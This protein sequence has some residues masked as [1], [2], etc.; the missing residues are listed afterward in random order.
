MKKWLLFSL[1]FIVIVFSVCSQVSDS[2][3]KIVIDKQVELILNSGESYI[4][5][6]KEYD[7]ANV[8]FLKDDG[9]ILTFRRN[10]IEGIRVIDEKKEGR[11]D[12]SV[13]SIYL[14]ALGFLQMGPVIGTDFNIGKENLLG[15]QFRLTGV[16]LLYTLIQPT[17][18]WY[19][20]GPAITYTKLFPFKKNNN[21][22]YLCGLVGTNLAFDQRFFA[23][24]LIIAVRSG[25]RWRFDSKLFLNLGLWVGIA[26]NLYHKVYYFSVGTFPT[27]IFGGLEFSI[28]FET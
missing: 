6:V 11:T 23:L 24:N 21:R 5:V 19:S 15:I 2:V 17:A 18:Y 14:D 28:G 3:L 4:G 7:D 9:L 13:F 10:T 26:P 12:T 20:M 25:Y 22:F 1:F 27:W 8:V 16:G